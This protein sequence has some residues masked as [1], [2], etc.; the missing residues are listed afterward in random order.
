MRDLATNVQQLEAALSHLDE[1]Q[2]G[3][4]LAAVRISGVLVDEA[5][6]KYGHVRQM[7]YAAAGLD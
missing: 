1:E 2:S 5:Y 4:R 7:L 6:S 3:D